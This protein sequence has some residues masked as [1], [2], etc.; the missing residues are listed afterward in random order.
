MFRL[1]TTTI[2]P[3]RPSLVRFASTE[4]PVMKAVRESLKAAMRSGDNSRKT[5]IRA[6]MSQIKN[7]N[8]ESTGAVATDIQFYDTV[9]SMA[10][11]RSK[12]AEEFAEAGRQD[13]ADKE[14]EEI[15]I[16]EELASQVDMATE[17][18]VKAHIQ[19]IAAE[20]GFDSL[21]GIQPGK[22]MKLV[23]WG[24]IEA[25]W[26]TSRA[27]VVDLVKKLTQAAPGSKRQFSTSRSIG[28][29]NPLVRI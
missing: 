10:K 21:S 6:V 15:K 24:S 20:K 18:E 26:K 14:V 13:L 29:E 28:H 23:P 16:L 3:L 17:E 8:L 4:P 27:T 11:K 19:R 12:S 1:A 25:E 2:R 22:V 5:V 7:A 9:K